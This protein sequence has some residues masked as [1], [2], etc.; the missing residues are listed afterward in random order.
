MALFT[1]KKRQ[2]LAY[3]ENMDEAFNRLD[4]HLE[5]NS[6]VDV[7]AVRLVAI[8]IGAKEMNLGRIQAALDK[9]NRSVL[10]A[11]APA[12]VLKFERKYQLVSREV[13]SLLSYSC[14]ILFNRMLN[15]LIHIYIMSFASSFRLC[16]QLKLCMYRIYRINNSLCSFVRFSLLCVY[17]FIVYVILADPETNWSTVKER[18]QTAT[19]TS[20]R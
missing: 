7:Q 13:C 12:D 19:C 16:H 6:Y 3:T 18:L 14:S 9:A 5:V 15:K 8:N 17:N 10:I 4:K 1:N 11:E 2:L 20:S